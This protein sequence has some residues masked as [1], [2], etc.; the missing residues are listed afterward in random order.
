[1]SQKAFQ[2]CY[3]DFTSHCYGCGRLNPQGR[4]VAVLAPKAMSAPED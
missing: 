4:V 2:D 3:S 1:M